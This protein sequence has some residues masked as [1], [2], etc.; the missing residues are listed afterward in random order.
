LDDDPLRLEKAKRV[1]NKKT[2]FFGL[3][4]GG[5]SNIFTGD[6]FEALKKSVHKKLQNVLISCILCWNHLEILN[7]NDYHFTRHG[8]FAFY[9]ED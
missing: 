9:Q 1:E 5:E 6:Y 7:W 8:V 4:G 2:G 3:F